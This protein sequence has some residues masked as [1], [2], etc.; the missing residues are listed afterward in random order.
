MATTSQQAGTDL[1]RLWYDWTALS[2]EAAQV[3]GLRMI[4]L[5]GG[6]AHAERETHRMI[7]EKVQALMQV[8][9][10]L[11]WGQWGHAPQRQIEGMTRLYSRKV[12]A[13]LHR[14]S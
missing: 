6:G 3:I 7:D 10:K 1:V 9:W 12:R 11:A 2:F 4:V 5:A 14:L 13:N 8:G